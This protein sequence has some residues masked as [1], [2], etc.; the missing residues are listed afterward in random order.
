VKR[1][2]WLLLAIPALLGGILLYLLAPRVLRPRPTQLEPG[3]AGIVNILIVGRDARAVGPVANEGRQRNKRETESHSDIMILCHVNLDRGRM[4]FVNV[5]R[6]MLVRVPGVTAA[7]SET[8]FR[9][10]EKI[11]HVPVIGG[12]KLLRRTI[13]QLLGITI[14]RTIAF[15]FDTFRMTFGALAPF[16]GRLRVSGVAL[17]D[18]QQALMFARR[19]HGLAEDDVDR[20][21]NSVILVRAMLNRLW[22][23]RQSRL[24]E[25]LLRNVLGIVGTDT[26]LTFDEVFQLVHGLDRAGFE[27]STIKTAVLVGEGASVYMQ[28]YDDTLSCYLPAYR[29]IEK[30]TRKYL[31]DDD[32][33]EALSFMTRQKYAAPGYLF[34]DYG[35]PLTAESLPVTDTSGLSTRDKELLRQGVQPD[36]S[37]SSPDSVQ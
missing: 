31:L 6:D 29:E 21:R 25:I 13:E 8:D 33:A 10:M 17:G 28:R 18:R 23:L 24:G 12:D 20:S 15:D 11:T 1:L 35:L 22:W 7:A 16:L 37:P 34:G 5:P 36:T 19:R 3:P 2:W 9:N 26:D 27:P 30:Q 14:H 4:N 32:S